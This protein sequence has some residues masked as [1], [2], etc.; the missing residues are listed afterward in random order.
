MFCKLPCFNSRFLIETLK[1]TLRER[2]SIV[3]R[4]V[5][6]KMVR[7]VESVIA[8]RLKAESLQDPQVL[9]R[10]KKSWACGWRSKGPSERIAFRC[11]AT[12]P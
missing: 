5:P 10:V 9:A 3:S 4:A 12:R 6:G 1:L 7:E 11:A 2:C 8:R